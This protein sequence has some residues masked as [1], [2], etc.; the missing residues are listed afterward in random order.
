[1]RV[2]QPSIRCLDVEDPSRA[3][4]A[5]RAFSL[6]LVSLLSVL[7][8][9]LVFPAFVSVACLLSVAFCL[10]VCSLASSHGVPYARYTLGALALQVEVQM[11]SRFSCFGRIDVYSRKFTR[12]ECRNGLRYCNSPALLSESRAPA[13]RLRGAASAPTQLDIESG[14]T[15]HNS[16][17][18]IIHQNI[19]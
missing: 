5:S 8:C 10:L 2:T 14:S 4:A 13:S 11:R 1:M 12:L 9:F 6:L 15:I 16:L 19:I 18:C 17:C 7:L 3:L